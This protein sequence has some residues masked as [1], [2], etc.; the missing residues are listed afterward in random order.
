MFLL[1]VLYFA[2][3]SYPYS[4]SLSS[5]DGMVSGSYI[6][7]D[8]DGLL[9]LI[10][11]DTVYMSYSSLLITRQTDSGDLTEVVANNTADVYSGRLVVCDID[12]DGSAEIVTAG[13]PGSGD[14]VRATVW[15]KSQ[16]T[17]LW[18]ANQTFNVTGALVSNDGRDVF[19]ALADMS[20]DD[21]PD[22]V[23]VSGDLSFSQA[24]I[25]VFAWNQSSDSFETFPLYETN[26]TPMSYV[27]SMILMDVDSNG[28]EDLLISSD[29][30]IYQYKWNGTSFNTGVVAASGISGPVV[31]GD[32]DAD[33]ALDLAVFNSTGLV[34]LSNVGGYFSLSQILLTAEALDYRFLDAGDVDSDGDLDIVFGGWYSSGG[35]KVYVA[36]NNGGNFAI[37]QTILDV[38]VSGSPVSGIYNGVV[39]YLVDV[40]YDGALDLLVGLPLASGQNFRVFPNI[41]L[42]RSIS[43]SCD[44]N[45]LLSWNDVPSAQG[46]YVFKKQSEPFKVGM[47]YIV[48]WRNAIGGIASE[49]VTEG[50][51]LV[52]EVSSPDCQLEE[53]GDYFV[54]AYRKGGY[55]YFPRQRG[56]NYYP[57]MQGGA[58]DMISPGSGLAE[59]VFDMLKDIPPDASAVLLLPKD[60][61]EETGGAFVPGESGMDTLGIVVKTDKGKKVVVDIFT[62]LGEKVARVE[63]TADS[64]QSRI[65]WK[66]PDNLP[67]GTYIAV[68]SVDGKVVE[69]K[70]F[71]V[72]K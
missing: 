1:A 15:R 13:S 18:Y 45:G 61:L 69:R 64:S 44:E 60:V 32:F 23:M 53:S 25:S 41:F 36:I 51:T 55:C 9:E 16:T 30:D 57:P 38:S 50:C 28:D 71:A 67:P 65:D 68:V 6:D 26:S 48:D 40:N 10:S 4:L 56:N 3:L 20:G 66:V 33:G 59:F 27:Y 29:T 47:G 7:V 24:Y 49:L 34:I 2:N 58:V 39:A 72:V 52:A 63:T 54:V 62:I 70:K 42:H 22:L 35:I 31:S 19:V 14:P 11:L 21:Y 12:D 46:F 5:Y 37:E 17:G 43:V 8:G